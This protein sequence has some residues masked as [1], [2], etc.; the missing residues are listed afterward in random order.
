[1][2]DAIYNV[3]KILFPETQKIQNKFKMQILKMMSRN[4]CT[5]IEKKMTKKEIMFMDREEAFYTN[6]V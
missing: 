1:M 5:K 6:M 3:V 4:K 2:E